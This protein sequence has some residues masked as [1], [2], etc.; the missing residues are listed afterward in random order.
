[1][2]P[3]TVKRL[4]ILI[5]IV[6]VA[7]LSIYFLQRSQ[8]TRMAKS[9]LEEAQEAEKG[10]DYEAAIQKYQEHLMVVPDDDVTKEKLADVLLKGGK[11]FARQAQA[12]QLYGEIL[13]RNPQRSDIRRRLAELSIERAQFKE[14]RPNLEILLKNDELSLDAR[15]ATCI[16]CSAVA[17]RT[18]SDFEE[19]E[20]SY[21]DRHRQWC[22]PEGRGDPAPGQPAPR[23][24]QA[25]GR[26]R[27]DHRPDGE[28]RCRRTIRSTSHAGGI[29]AASAS[30][31][32]TPI[33]AGC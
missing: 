8:V 26:G 32:P 18:T 23:A 2:G 10:G 25:G 21:K 7:S 16:S 12:A 9:V 6:V 5:A 17:R 33:S 22:F 14:A 27:P 29:A 11:D 30:R 3:K 15:T 13:T 19:A 28:R 24:A 31:T 4:V 1:M 20:E